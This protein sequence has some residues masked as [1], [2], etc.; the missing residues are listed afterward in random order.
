MSTIASQITSVSILYSTFCS[1]AD[2]RSKLCVTGLCD[3]KWPVTGEFPAQRA[4][5]L[6]N[7]YRLMMSSWSNGW[8]RLDWTN[9]DGT[10]FVAIVERHEDAMT[11]KHF[12]HYWTFVREIH[13]SLADSHHKRPVT[14]A[15]T[16]FF[17][18][19][20]KNCWENSLIANDL[21]CHDTQFKSLQSK[22]SNE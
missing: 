18:V 20:L 3:G 13:R 19:C 15:L 6:E 21:R 10:W 9:L 2:Q 4:S 22:C 5:D 16:F 11:W 1:D 17:H 12:P 8:Q 14:W 7:F